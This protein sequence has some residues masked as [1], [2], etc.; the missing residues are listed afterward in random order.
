MI[1]AMVAFAIMAIIIGATMITLGNA[2]RLQAER[3]QSL[4]LAEVSRSILEEYTV[5][6]PN[7]PRSG[8]A[9]GT[10][11][12]RI[13][14][15]AIVPDPPGVLAAVM[16]YVE[17]GLQVWRTDRPERILETSTLMARRVKE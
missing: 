2:T 11:S 1:E 16:E 6:Y 14:E 7:L 5:S 13:S 12:W 17:I 10:W 4:E 3:L 15:R 8:E 9:N